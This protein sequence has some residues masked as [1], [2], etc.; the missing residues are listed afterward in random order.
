LANQRYTI[1]LVQRHQTTTSSSCNKFA[2]KIY[3]GT[4]IRKTNLVL[5]HMRTTTATT[6]T[7]PQEKEGKGLATPDDN[8][9]TPQYQ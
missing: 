3:E 2:C 4:E 8:F 5:Q 7:P 6:T 1:I 9:K